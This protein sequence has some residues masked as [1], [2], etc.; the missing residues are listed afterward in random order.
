MSKPKKYGIRATKQMKKDLILCFEK[1]GGQIYKSLETLDIPP[2][3]YYSWK[4]E[5]VEFST[6]VENRLTMLKELRID[7]AESQLDKNI[8]NGNQRAIEYLL[9]R[10]GRERGYTDK[11]TLE[12]ETNEVEKSFFQFG[13]TIEGGYQVTLGND[14]HEVNRNFKQRIGIDGDFEEK[15]NTGKFGKMIENNSS[16]FIDNEDGD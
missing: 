8:M 6:K 4:E 15:Y 10:Q 7:I 12:V 11:S 3:I 1:T 2:S 16:K 5:D 13:E 9:S 14:P